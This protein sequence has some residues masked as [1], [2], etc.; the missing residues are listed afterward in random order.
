M[1]AAADS[2]WSGYSIAERDR[3]WQ[4]VRANAARAELDCVFVPRCL[5]GRNFQ[6]SLE[7]SHGTQSDS[8]YLT[9]M[10]DTAF[11]LPT[12]GRPPIAIND[13][14]EG[15]DWLPQ[16]RPASAGERGSWAPAMAAALRELGFERGRIGVSG[17]ARGKVT[18]GR[19]IAGVVNHSAFTETR[20]SLP[21]ATFVDAT[22]VVG[23]ARYVKSAEEIECLRKGAEIAVAGIERMIELAR[24]GITQA[25]LYAAVMERMLELG[26]EYYPLALY[27]API[28]EDTPRMENPV[29]DQT[30]QSG[31]ALTYECDAVWGG[32]IAQELQPILLGPTPEDWKPVIDLQRELFEMGLQMM[33]PGVL[34]AEVIDAINEHGPKR[35]MHSLILMH[36]RGY[37]DDG[38]LLTPQDVR[39]EH[40]RDVPFEAGNCFVWKPIA[41]NAD[42]SIQYS[43]GGCIAVT[44]HGAEQ[45]VK[46]EQGVVNI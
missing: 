25:E 33:K 19:A 46:R 43:W 11:I 18:H 5:D 12:D 22:D 16:T 34:F 14:G 15:N 26:S 13:R 41:Y 3:R 44:D 28:G 35:E 30:L 32:I 37:G 24:P 20:R 27:S 4:A 42:R 9:Q 45:L 1:E 39:A 36:G 23:F 2:T 38:P 10:E 40:F 17:L 7:Q 8:R 31:F 6:L 21:D 29:I